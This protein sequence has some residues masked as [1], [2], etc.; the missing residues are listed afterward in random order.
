[1]GQKD[2]R[3]NSA[4][5]K[6]FRRAQYIDGIESMRQSLN[7]NFRAEGLRKVCEYFMKRI[8]VSKFLSNSKLRRARREC[9]D[10]KSFV[11]SR[12]FQQSPKMWQSMKLS[13]QR[14]SQRILIIFISVSLSILKAFRV[15]KGFTLSESGGKR[16]DSRTALLK[17]F[18]ALF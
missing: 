12:S 18:Q 4:W 1:M 9:R 3:R 10:E 14:W 8:S 15:Q 6:I 17:P 13:M 2:R 7:L 5:T 16:E 11:C